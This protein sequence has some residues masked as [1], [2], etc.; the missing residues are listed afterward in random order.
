MITNKNIFLRYYET[1]DININT[2]LK[3]IKKITNDKS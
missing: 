2:F 3:K 1:S